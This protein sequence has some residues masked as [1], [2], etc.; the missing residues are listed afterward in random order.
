MEANIYI[1]ITLL[2][3]LIVLLNFIL[4]ENLKLFNNCFNS[5][6][7][8]K[9]NVI[10]KYS[11]ADVYLLSYP[12]NNN[13]DLILPH[14]RNKKKSTSKDIEKEHLLNS[15]QID[16][17]QIFSS[18]YIS[19]ISSLRANIPPTCTCYKCINMKPNTDLNHKYV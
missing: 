10:Q 3:K 18:I 2:L 14:W 7:K 4:I 6:R 8:I 16:T 17:C 15:I 11:N 12:N 5:Q 13:I 1:L 9:R 19:I